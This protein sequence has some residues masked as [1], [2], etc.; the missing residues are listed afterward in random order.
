MAQWIRLPILECLHCGHRWVGKM[1]R[2]AD[3]QSIKGKF[4]E[5]E[6]RV[7][8]GC[9]SPYFDSPPRYKHP[10]PKLAMQRQKEAI[11][12]RVASKAFSDETEAFAAEVKKLKEMENLKLDAEKTQQKS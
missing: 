5:V 6:V 3:L 1:P 11:E 12:R 2:G 9:K 8:A 10:N 4:I 7:C